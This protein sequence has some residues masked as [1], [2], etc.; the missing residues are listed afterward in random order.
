MALNYPFWGEGSEWHVSQEIPDLI[1][2]QTLLY[3]HCHRVCQLV[4]EH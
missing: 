3:S 4:L 1:L 2:A